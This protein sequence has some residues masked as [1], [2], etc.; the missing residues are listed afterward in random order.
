MADDRLIAANE[1]Y[2]NLLGQYRISITGVIQKEAGQGSRSFA[3]CLGMM[4]SRSVSAGTLQTISIFILPT[5][6][7]SLKRSTGREA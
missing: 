2:T 3:T 7:I 5:G 4:I 6:S 1:E